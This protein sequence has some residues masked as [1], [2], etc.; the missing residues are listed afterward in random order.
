MICRRSIKKVNW[1]HCCFNA[2]SI[3]ALKLGS[4][5]FSV[6]VYNSI[7]VLA[8]DADVNTW[9]HHLT[10][11]T[12]NSIVLAWTLTSI[13]AYVNFKMLWSFISTYYTLCNTNSLFPSWDF[14]TRVHFRHIHIH[15]EHSSVCIHENKITPS[16]C[17]YKTTH[18]K[19][20]GF[21]W[22]L[23][24]EQLAKIWQSKSIFVNI[25]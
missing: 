9:Q 11:Q 7:R 16:I 12:K 17:I 22:N 13:S 6:S 20:N 2:A 25:R 18:K 19:M 5:L 10:C 3:H 4:R 24:V 1:S 14:S 23:I 21:S 15:V 8:T